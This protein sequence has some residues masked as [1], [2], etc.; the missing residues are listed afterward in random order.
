VDTNYTISPEEM[1]TI[2]QYLLGQMDIEKKTAFEY[3]MNTDNIMASKVNEVK[4]LLAGIEAASLKERLNTYHDNIKTDLS[5]KGRSKVIFLQRKWLAAASV[6]LIAVLSVLFYTQRENKY[7]KLYAQYY[8]PDP[9]LMSAMGVGDNYLFNKAML[10]YKT[11][12]YKLAIEEWSKLKTS[13]D[14]NDTLNYFLGAAQQAEG[15]S[16]AALTLLHSLA[17]DDTRPFYKD[18]CWYTGLALLRQGK[19][20]EAVSYLEKSGR[21]ERNEIISL[22]K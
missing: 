19:I 12:N 21:P 5:Q 18:A 20:N 13:A 14:P 8:K 15:N 7:E 11:G 9:G 4:L 17:S 2:E 16:V 6:V 22:L 3:K 1:I 10:D